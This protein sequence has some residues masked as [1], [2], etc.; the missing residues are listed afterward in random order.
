MQKQIL[1][2]WIDGWTIEN[3]ALKHNVSVDHVV[4]AIRVMRVLG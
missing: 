4:T 1:A 2:H 3:I